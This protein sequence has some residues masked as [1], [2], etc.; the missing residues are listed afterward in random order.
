MTSAPPPPAPASVVHPWKYLTQQCSSSH[1]SPGSFT[2][3]VED[4]DTSNTTLSP[5]L[6]RD[7]IV[8]LWAD[9]TVRVSVVTTPRP[10]HLHST[11]KHSHYTHWRHSH[12]YHT[13]DYHVLRGRI[14]KHLSRFIKARFMYQ[15][16]SNDQPKICKKFSVSPLQI[17][18]LNGLFV[19]GQTKS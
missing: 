7:T 11:H 13:Q 16:L 14:D 19:L 12:R 18:S 15:I 8:Q 4:T 10:T 2:L 5:S 1:R 9:N 17:W 6:D 3:A